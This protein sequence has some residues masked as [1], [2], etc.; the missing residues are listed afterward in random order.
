MG[1]DR[2][3]IDNWRRFGLCGKKLKSTRKGA[4]L[5]MRVSDVQAF[6]EKWMPRGVPGGA[7]RE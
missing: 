6:I 7:P 1:I 3:R 2:D 5:F 4:R